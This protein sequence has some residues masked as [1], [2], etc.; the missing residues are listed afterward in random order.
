MVAS[1]KVVTVEKARKRA[2]VVCKSGMLMVTQLALMRSA[3]L[4][5]PVKPNEW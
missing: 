3:Q 5:G 1:T 2:F 4:Q